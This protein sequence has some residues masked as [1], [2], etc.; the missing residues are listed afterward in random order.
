MSDR[1]LSLLVSTVLMIAPLTANCDEI[2]LSPET[3]PHGEFDR[4]ERM[5]LNRIDRPKPLAVSDG[6]GLVAGTTEPLAVHSGM[7][8]LRKG[9]NA[10]DAC[11]GDCSYRYR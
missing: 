9:G 3:W 2:S 8:A 4:L 1:L 10:M 6:K 7:D 5:T 11:L